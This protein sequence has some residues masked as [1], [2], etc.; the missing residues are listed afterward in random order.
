LAEGSPL[1]EEAVAGMH[2]LGPGRLAGLYDLFRY[3]VALGS[4]RRADMHRFV[5]HLD[6]QRL[7]I[8]VGIDGDGGDAHPAR[9]LDDAA[10]DLAA[11]GD[12]Y[13]L[14]H[15]RNVPPQNVPYYGL[16]AAGSIRQTTKG[17]STQ[18]EAGGGGL[19]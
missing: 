7:A 6:M 9:R 11:I 15:A 16:R 1:R 19:R 13:L 18:T 4:G 14:E 2:R 10:G 8:G 5:R 3:Q 17:R 12:Q